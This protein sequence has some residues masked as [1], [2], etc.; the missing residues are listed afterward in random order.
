MRGGGGKQNPAMQAVLFH[1]LEPAKEGEDAEQ[2][3]PVSESIDLQLDCESLVEL[4][5]ENHKEGGGRT[6]VTATAAATAA[7][8]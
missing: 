5:K 4:A 8:S 1:D 2:R 6:E 7:E 3:Q